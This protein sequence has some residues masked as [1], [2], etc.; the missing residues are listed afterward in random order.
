VARIRRLR[1]LVMHEPPAQRRC[2]QL[3]EFLGFLA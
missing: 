3:Q 2:Q 1:G